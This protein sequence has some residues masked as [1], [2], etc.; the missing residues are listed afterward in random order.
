MRPDVHLDAGGAR[1][2]RR[3]RRRSGRSGLAAPRRM[4]GQKDRKRCNS[5]SIH[6][7]SVVVSVI[8]TSNEKAT[9]EMGEEA[10][11]RDAG[12][13]APTSVF[14]L[15]FQTHDLLKDSAPSASVA[16][17]PKQRNDRR[18][19]EGKLFKGIVWI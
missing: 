15:H 1:R 3:R 11:R 19:E 18:S 4:L 9:A 12:L 13:K 6:N 10:D 16:D 5:G 7:I 2:R 17:R 8:E 14:V